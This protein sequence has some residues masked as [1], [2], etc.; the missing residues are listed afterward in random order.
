MYDLELYL[1][2]IAIADTDMFILSK[3]CMEKRFTFRFYCIVK[4]PMHSMPITTDV[5]GSKLD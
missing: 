5:V 4:V 2:N 3:A 1:K